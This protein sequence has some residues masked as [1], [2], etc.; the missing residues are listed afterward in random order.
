MGC[1]LVPVCPS[2]SLGLLRLGMHTVFG[3][4]RVAPSLGCSNM[5]C[6]DVATLG[7]GSRL[8]RSRLRRVLLAYTRPI[9]FVH[10]FPNAKDR[11]N[12]CS[13]RYEV[14]DWTLSGTKYM[15]RQ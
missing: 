4:M 14:A 11:V 10:P 8:I 1:L 13:V 7:R 12:R 6:Y 5:S 2:P 15:I 9:R 3:V